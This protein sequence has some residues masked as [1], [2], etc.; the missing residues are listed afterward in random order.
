MVYQFAHICKLNTAKLKWV[1]DY[2]VLNKLVKFGAKIFAHYTDIMIF[3]LGHFNL[4]HPVCQL[5]PLLSTQC[6]RLVQPLL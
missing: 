3:V 2:Y 6:P 1:Y 4:A 5:R